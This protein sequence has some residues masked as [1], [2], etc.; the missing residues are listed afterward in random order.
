MSIVITFLMLGL[1][2]WPPAAL[3]VRSA[4]AATLSSTFVT[5]ARASGIPEWKL[6]RVHVLP[7]L[8]PVLR[9]QF[10]LLIPLFILAEA[11]LGMLGLGV[12]EPLPSWG[13]LLGELRHLGSFLESPWLLAPALQLFVSVVCFTILAARKDATL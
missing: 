5:Q 11:N 1:L 8:R 7:H 2:G 6:F 4:A 9:A 10:L 13:A 3:V 12:S